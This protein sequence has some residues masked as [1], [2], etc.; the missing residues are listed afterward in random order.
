MTTLKEAVKRFTQL[1]SELM[2]QRL[3]R[4]GPMPRVI[5]D[6]DT[7]N[8]IDDQ[9]AVAW[10]LLSQDRMRL[11]GV[12]AAPFSFTHHRDG[13]YEAVAASVSYTH[14]TLPTKA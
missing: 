5:I 6:T 13:L 4:P 9:Y 12:T 10:A 8:E 14:L 7:A 3:G 11:E 1:D 2:K